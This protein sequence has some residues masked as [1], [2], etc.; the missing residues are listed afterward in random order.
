MGSGSE[1]GQGA[2]VA[3]GGGNGVGVMLGRG[4]DGRGG[5]VGSGALA[6]LETLALQLA[7][8]SASEMPARLAR[9]RR[10]RRC[11]ARRLLKET[12][13]TSS[14]TA[15]GGEIRRRTA[16]QGLCES[17]PDTI[18]AVMRAQGAANS[19]TTVQSRTQPLSLLRRN[20]VRLLLL[21]PLLSSGLLSMR[22]DVV[23]AHTP[24]PPQVGFTFRPYTAAALGLDPDAALTQL[25]TDVRPDV[26]RLPV[27]WSDVAT[28]PSVLDFT[29]PD[30]LV[31]TVAEYDAHTPSR[32]ATIVLVVGMRNVGAPELYAPLWALNAV[33]GKYAS[34]L[35]ALPGFEAY[36]DATVHHYAAN[37]L[38]QRWQVE[39]EPLDNSV[40]TS[41]GVTSRSVA[42]IAAEVAEV[43]SMDP[44]HPVMTTT[45]TSSVLDLD[46][47]EIAQADY[48]ITPPPGPQPGG[49]PEESL[50]LGNTL[51]VDLYV[52]YAGVALTDADAAT[53]IIWKRNSLGFWVQRAAQR[54]KNVWIA[55]M[56]AAP[57]QHV[58][59]FTT[60][61][62]LMSAH[63]YRGQGE[64]AV[65]LWGVE[66]WLTSPAWLAAGRQAV[67]LLRS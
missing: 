13:P 49:H 36:V 27:Y 46:Q 28:S 30:D 62:L 24:A 33:G 42:E 40:P 37:P 35:A 56:Q 2:G 39:N 43:R 19:I 60:D 7:I 21:V 12:C 65:L 48:E 15:V 44:G 18:R 23:Q 16:A 67:A 22:G 4:N 31:A 58:D 32:R 52:V 54:N 6:A 57:W 64:S 34:Q 1:L 10:R 14:L 26:V 45:F 20:R 5:R 9:V 47:E 25:L 61:D 8:S 50:A 29:A 66:Q 53:R 63:E 38:L 3:G 41:E 17:R 55:E 11:A 59:G 51:G